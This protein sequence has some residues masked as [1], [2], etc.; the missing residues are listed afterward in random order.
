MVYTS[1]YILCKLK[2]IYNTFLKDFWKFEWCCST[3]KLI[4]KRYIHYEK[5]VNHVLKYDVRSNVI[6]ISIIYIME[7]LCK[8]Y[9]KKYCSIQH[10]IIRNPHIYH[11]KD[12]KITSF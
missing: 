3:G 1:A 4:G 10:S 8:C 7:D 11:K 12:V 9:C 2:C 6:S 5:C